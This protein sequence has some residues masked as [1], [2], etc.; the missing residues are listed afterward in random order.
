MVDLHIERLEVT[1]ISQA[2][3]FQGDEKSQWE[4]AGTAWFS[5]WVG[6]AR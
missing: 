5:V 2:G 3:K 1:F 4:P 6:S